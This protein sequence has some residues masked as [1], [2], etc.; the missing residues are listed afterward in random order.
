MR[1]STDTYHDLVLP[2]G[3]IARF[4]NLAPEDIEYLNRLDAVVNVFA[5]YDPNSGQF[6]R[7]EHDPIFSKMGKPWALVKVADPIVGRDNSTF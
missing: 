4:T 1:V 5:W 6:S 7:E 3:A 2:S